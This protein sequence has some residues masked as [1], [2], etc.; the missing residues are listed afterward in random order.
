MTLYIYACVCVLVISCEEHTS[1]FETMI[2]SSVLNVLGSGGARDG[3]C[4]HQ[5]IR[6]VVVVENQITLGHHLA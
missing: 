6:I 2:P 3:V 1:S 5:L 4:L